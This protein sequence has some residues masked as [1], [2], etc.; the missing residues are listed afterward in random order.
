MIKN[1]FILAI[2]F[3]TFKSFADIPEYSCTTFIHGIDGVETSRYTECNIVRWHRQETNDDFR[4]QIVGYQSGY[5]QF[6]GNVYINSGNEVTRDVMIASCVAQSNSDYSDCSRWASYGAAGS[7]SA[8][9]NLN[10]KKRLLCEIG[11]IIGVTEF[12]GEYCDSKRS[13]RE[14]DCFAMQLPEL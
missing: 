2:I 14:L 7:A 5:Y 12:I 10:G 8:C 4:R 11:T 1:F 13:G 9:N 6:T 3:I